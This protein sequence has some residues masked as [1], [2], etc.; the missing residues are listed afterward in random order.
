MTRDF[1]W[2]DLWVL[3]LCLSLVYAA[4]RKRNLRL[5]FVAMLSRLFMAEGFLRGFLMKPSPP[6]GFHA[7]F[8]VVKES[9][10]PE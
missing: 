8:Q 6:E 10:I 1:R 4:F 7:D 9:R 5:A 3:G 2:I